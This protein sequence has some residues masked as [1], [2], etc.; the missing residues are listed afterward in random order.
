[1]EDS[2]SST[3]EDAIPADW[4]IPSRERTLLLMRLNIAAYPFC[5]EKLHHGHSCSF[6][7][8]TMKQLFE[9]GQ[10]LYGSNVTTM[11]EEQTAAQNVEM[12]NW[13][14]LIR[15]KYFT[16]TIRSIP[17]DTAKFDVGVSAMEWNVGN[18]TTILTFRGTFSHGD[19]DN[20][21]HWMMDFLLE[22]STG[23]MKQAWVEDA[24]LE[25]T[26]EKEARLDDHNDALAK[27]EIRAVQDYKEREFPKALEDAI[28]MAQ[29]NMTLQS[30]LDGGGLTLQ[31]ARDTGYWKLT[32]Y[33]VDQVF[34][35]TTAE[36]RTLILTG[37]SQG[38][39]RAQLASMYLQHTYGAKVPT[40]SFAAT[41]AACMARRL[42]DTSANM[43]QDVNPFVEHDQ[44]V[45]YVHPLDPWGNAM[46]GEDAGGQV[47]YFDDDAYDEAD[48]AIQYCSKVYEW[49][50]PM[51]VANEHS[52]TPNLE[53]KQ[54]F[55]RCRYFTHDA[56]AMFFALYETLNPNGTTTHRGCSTVEAIPENDPN[57]VCP[58]GKLSLSEEEDIFGLIVALAIVFVLL[59]LC[60][61]F[62]C[63]K[64]RMQIRGYSLGLDQD[65]L[66]AISSNSDDEDL[67]Y[68]DEEPDSII[69]LP[70]IA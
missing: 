2:S 7:E 36:N 13:N 1:M 64:R 8:D 42:F 4:T 10:S 40:V 43:L 15:N 17:E 61:C 29:S 9:R 34:A 59:P 45:E 14:D 28:T 41:G 60:V 22:K 47:C 25:W 16:Y 56:K 33:I 50:G 55:Q 21:E 68:S 23:R 65:R 26:P 3:T 53:L 31:D 27:V 5:T 30:S 67:A 52:P 51:L 20:I 58:T 39:T 54:N 48:R 18:S 35:K 70:T 38:G 49:P 63:C 66:D 62:W 19:Y 37:H 11:E 12:Q 57:G 46:L 32:K 44:I 6:P 24:G 69:E